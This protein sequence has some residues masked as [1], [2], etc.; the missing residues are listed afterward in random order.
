MS[1]TA[2]R[3]PALEQVDWLACPSSCMGWEAPGA[4]FGVR[5]YFTYGAARICAIKITGDNPNGLGQGGLARDRGQDP[6]QFLDLH[7]TPFPEPAHPL[8]ALT[9]PRFASLPSFPYPPKSLRWPN[10]S[11][12]GAAYWTSSWRP[13]SA[14]LPAPAPFLLVQVCLYGM[15]VTM[16]S[17]CK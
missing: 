14:Q 16:L 5:G 3:Q 4:R 13:P 15:F 6:A 8:S 2:Q 1:L 17:M 10:S 7:S 9:L 12:V 11:G